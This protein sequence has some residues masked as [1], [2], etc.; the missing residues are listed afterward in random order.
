MPPES[1]CLPLVRARAALRLQDWRHSRET[2]SQQNRDMFFFFPAALPATHARASCYLNAFSLNFQSVSFIDGERYLHWPS[3][4]ENAF[5]FWFRET[6]NLYVYHI[7]I[8]VVQ[9]IVSEMNLLFTIQILP[10]CY[11]TIKFQ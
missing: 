10:M 3:C 11:L 1:G 2:Q 7:L 6:R 9:V 4:F 5:M 8:V